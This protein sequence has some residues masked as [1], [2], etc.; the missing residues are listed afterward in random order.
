MM[1]WYLFFLKCLFFLKILR[2]FFK[3]I[4]D[5]RGFAAPAAAGC[6]VLMSDRLCSSIASTWENCLDQFL[7]CISSSRH[8]LPSLIEKTD[9]S[10][11]SNCLNFTETM[12]VTGDNS[13][14]QKTK[15]YF[16]CVLRRHSCPPGPSHYLVP[17]GIRIS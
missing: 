8:S 15:D 9:I 12:P 13:Q 14:Q 11:S 4:S 10:P 16:K 1:L 7:F 2:R 5:R 17:E 3:K 6:A